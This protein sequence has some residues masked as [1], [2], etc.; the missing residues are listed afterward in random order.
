MGAANGNKAVTD[1]L[2][3][4]KQNPIILRFRGEWRMHF[5]PVRFSLELTKL[6]AQPQ[7]VQILTL[8]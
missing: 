3:Q 5:C 7:I 2:G 1:T 4:Q 8:V 6:L